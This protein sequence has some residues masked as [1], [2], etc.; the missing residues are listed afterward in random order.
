MIK[1]D[2]NNSKSLI[3]MMVAVAMQQILDQYTDALLG[4]E[5]RKKLLLSSNIEQLF[6]L[7]QTYRDEIIQSIIEVNKFEQL[8]EIRAL[9]NKVDTL[10]SLFV[11]FQGDPNMSLSVEEELS[12]IV[13][14]FWKLRKN[15]DKFSIDFLSVLKRTI[16]DYRGTIDTKKFK[17]NDEYS[18]ATYLAYFIKKY[19]TGQELN[20]TYREFIVPFWDQAQKNINYSELEQMNEEYCKTLI[21]KLVKEFIC[22][23]DNKLYYLVR[24]ETQLNYH[25]MVYLKYLIIKDNIQDENI[26]E[27]LK[28]QGDI[29]IDP[30]TK[31]PFVW[32]VEKRTI[33][34]PLTESKYLP[35]S[36]RLAVSN[37]PEIKYLQVT[38]P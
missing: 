32:N 18:Y 19:P 25:N 3:N 10:E 38:I 34:L 31:E 16:K 7:Q 27:F 4:S 12:F 6:K 36:I 23:M 1:V 21:N 14:N 13:K 20:R 30:I 5:Y 26:P 8:L 33:S 17:Y 11:F 22:T 37:D 9:F 24:G 29:A 2:E 35:S 15:E 28:S